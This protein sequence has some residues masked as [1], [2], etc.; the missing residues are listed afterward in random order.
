L[1]FKHNL[2]QIKSIIHR[3]LIILSSNSSLVLL[4]FTAPVAY[5]FLYTSVFTNKMERDVAV[6]VVDNDKSVKSREIIRHLDA[7]E[8]IRIEGNYTSES[9]AY[10]QLQ[11]FK[12]MAI[13]VIPKGFEK[14]LKSGMQAKISIS[15]NNTRFMISNDVVKGIN[16][17][18]TDLAKNTTI[19]FFQQKGMSGEDSQL[20]ATPIQLNSKL[21]FN[22]TESYGDFIIVALLALILQQTL[23]I[24]TSVVMAHEKEMNTFQILLHKAS[25]SVL[26]LLVG[27]SFFYFI[28]YCGYAFLF[29]TFHFQL[30]KLPFEGSIWALTILTL[31]HFI[32]IIL[33]GMLAGTYFPSKL[34]TLVVLVFSSYPIFL[35]SGYSWPIQAFP[36]PLKIIAFLLPQTSYFQAFTIVTQEDGKLH[37]IL[38]QIFHILG[39]IVVL[40]TAFTVRI[41]YL[42]KHT[43]LN[44]VPYMVD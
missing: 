24:V 3:E 4:L 6:A 19:D 9:V 31:V 26:R 39:C 36:A 14:S 27:K 11:E 2:Q 30:Y 23:L 18:L 1:S 33:I 32:A 38:S 44:K 41:S 7:H 35:L 34:V 25:G 42:K 20:T 40:Y 29:F 8:L 37:D 15:I 21:L 10:R 43:H 13:I 12:C 22:T 16:D 5:S 17:I 28:I